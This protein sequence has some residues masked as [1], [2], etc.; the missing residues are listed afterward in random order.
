MCWKEALI[1]MTGGTEKTLIMAI[2]SAG[3]G[4]V[5]AGRECLLEYQSGERKATIGLLSIKLGSTGYNGRIER[6]ARAEFEFGEYQVWWQRRA[7]NTFAK[8]SSR[9]GDI[10]DAKIF[11][12]DAGGS[13]G[14]WSLVYWSIVGVSKLDTVTGLLY[15]VFDARRGR[16]GH[17][18]RAI[19]YR[20]WRRARYCN[21]VTL[22]RTCAGGLDG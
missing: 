3:R 19:V 20:T 12:G 14:R 9:Y 21:R 10:A 1:S 22:Y 6:R 5:S 11:I 2:V 7:M 16:R 13:A 17:Y 4:Y 15:I 18:E 8:I